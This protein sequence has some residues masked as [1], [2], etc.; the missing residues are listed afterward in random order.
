MDKDNS[1][2]PQPDTL[3][4][5]ALSIGINPPDQIKPPATTGRPPT[6]NKDT[7]LDIL[8]DVATTADKLSAIASNH[9]ITKKTWYWWLLINPQLGDSYLRALENRSHVLGMDITEDIGALESYVHD[10]SN[11]PRIMHAR[12]Q[13]HHRKSS[14][15][16]WLMSKYNRKVYGDQVS[17]D[18]TV[19]VQPAACRDAAWRIVQGLP[20]DG[21]IADAADDTQDSVDN[22]PA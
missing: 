8:V 11:D 9:G 4:A 12:I 13:L 22:L 20:A 6:Y 14:T 5:Q 16:Q 19:T 2:T 3:E 7:A 15:Y 1:N 10:E 17:I 21:D 18:Q